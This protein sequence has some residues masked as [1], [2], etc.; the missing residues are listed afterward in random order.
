M[1][2]KIDRR[3][4][5]FVMLDTETANGLEQP[6]AYDIGWAI[7]DKHGNVYRTRSFV[8]RDVFVYERNL[9]RTAYYAEKIPGYVN[10][11]RNGSRTMA[12]W[13]EIVKTLRE[14]CRDFQIKEIVA[15]NARFDLNAMNTTQRWITKSKYRYA[16]PYGTEILDTMRMAESVICKMPSYVKF[17]ED[18]GYLTQWGKP[19]KTAEILYRFISGDADFEEDHTGLADVMI[20]KEILAYCYRQHKAMEKKLFKD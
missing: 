20:E 7:I 5:Y 13:Y 4:H 14:D 12:D 6:L 10:D 18:N 3:R 9:M 16:F 19:R 17:C 8:N 2:Q 1:E 15:H 11:I